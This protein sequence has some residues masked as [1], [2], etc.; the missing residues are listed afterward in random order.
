[1]KLHDEGFQIQA[2]LRDRALRAES[3]KS[4][5]ACQ[6]LAAIDV[7]HVPSP[8]RRRL[9]HWMVLGLSKGRRTSGKTRES[10]TA[11][12]SHPMPVRW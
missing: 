12:T 5:R 6:H 4:D 1:M 11:I 9:T 3:D 8:E 2:V 7:C 10:P